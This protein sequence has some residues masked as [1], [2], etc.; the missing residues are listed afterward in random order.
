M[1]V[2]EEIG[3]QVSVLSQIEQWPADN[4]VSAVID[5]SGQMLDSVGDLNRK[6]P[7]ASVTKLLSAYAFLLALEE[8]AISLDDPAGPEG[9][10]VHHLLAHTSGYDFDSETIRFKPGSRRGYSNT[11][12][13][14]LAEHLQRSSGIEFNEYI[15]EAL[16]LPLGMNDTTLDGSSAKDGISTAADLSRFAAELLTPTLLAS[17]TLKNATSVHFPDRIGILPG[18]GRQEP[19]DWGLGFEIRGT[20]NPHWTGK[21]HPATTFGH[22]GQSG[23]FLWVDPEH[24]LACV[25][26]TDKAFGPWAA[27]RWSD[28]NNGV[29]QEFSR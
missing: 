15:S 5:G 12:F 20:K 29:L 11:G 16:F 14:V 4:A 2:S 17:E 7:L 24:R 26:L 10:T 9:S 28:Y 18:Y 19:N 13:E 23:T 8:E 3:I 25:T 6:Y 22:F 27:E 1:K 21:D